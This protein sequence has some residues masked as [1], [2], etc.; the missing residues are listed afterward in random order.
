MFTIQI[1]ANSP[2]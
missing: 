2:F 1:P